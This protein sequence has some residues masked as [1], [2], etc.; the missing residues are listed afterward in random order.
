[1][2]EFVVLAKFLDY[3]KKL[4]S[5]DAFPTLLAFE[6]LCLVALLSKVY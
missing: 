3:G 1:M 6:L 5:L 4:M 2:N